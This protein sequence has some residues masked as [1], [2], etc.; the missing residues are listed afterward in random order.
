M[1]VAIVTGQD[2]MTL[3]IGIVTESVSSILCIV[4]D[5]RTNC[6]IINIRIRL[7]VDVTFFA[8]FSPMRSF[9]CSPYSYFLLSQF[10]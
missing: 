8:M 10:L 5:N 1:E 7:A 4:P 2:D 9:I 6:E 3:A